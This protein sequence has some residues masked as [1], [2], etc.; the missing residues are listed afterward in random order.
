MNK[1]VSIKIAGYHNIDADNDD[2]AIEVINIG[3]YCKRNGKHYIK[4]DEPSRH[5]GNCAS[6]ILKIS[7][8]EIE[9]ITK[10]AAG[11]HMVFT[12]GQKNN[13]YYS[14][15][16]GAINMA[17]DTYDLNVS[18][19]ENTISVDI[20]YGLEMNLDYI[21]ECSVNIEIESVAE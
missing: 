4:Y 7:D 18:E 6:N 17:I 16:Y 9:I 5:D 21:A 20:K 15:P 19:E 12:M 14:T 8:R 1:K 13:T 11:N 10:G 3:T 2:E